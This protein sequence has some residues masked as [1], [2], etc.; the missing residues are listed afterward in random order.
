MAPE[1]DP[2][3]GEDLVTRMLASVGLA[4]LLLATAAPTTLSTWR[5]GGSFEPSTSWDDPTFM[6][7]DAA[8]AG[9]HRVYFNAITTTSS[10]PFRAS[11]N[12]GAAGTTHEPPTAEQSIALLG[13]WLD[14]NGD[15]YVGLA[16]HALPEYS[17]S[18]LAN[19]ATCPPSTGP[20]GT[21]TAG[22]HNY[23]GWVS[24]YV[25]IGP[26]TSNVDRRVYKD[27]EAMVWGDIR[28]PDEPASK[29]RCL[30]LGAGVVDADTVHETL[31]GADENDPKGK[32]RA[33]MNFEF[34]VAARGSQLAVVV[35]PGT[36]GAPNTDMAA[37]WV[38]WRGTGWYGDWTWASKPGPRIVHVDA[39]HGELA[40][41]EG[42]WLSFYGHVGHATFDR[43]FAM[44]EG[45]GTYG[46]AQCGG[47]PSGVR[48]GWNCDRALWNVDHNG[49]PIMLDYPLAAVGQPYELRDVDCFDGSNDLGLALG[50]PA[51][52]PAPCERR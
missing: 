7:T 45:R 40:F 51:Y 36:A 16:E 35:A 29:P 41:A 1:P 28:R 22:A 10:G 5:A 43:G 47:Q 52:G 34:I 15:G 3:V 49:D 42:Y 23:N 37:S 26:A 4:L 27:A 50:A 8:P 20:T 6:W 31:C 9:V 12:V 39:E 19:T 32:T 44:T 13:V 14:C 46:E 38:T 2:R 17:A 11:P 18:L 21:W 48:N 25:P 24:E 33:D 30:I